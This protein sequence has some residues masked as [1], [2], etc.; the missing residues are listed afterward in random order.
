MKSSEYGGRSISPSK[1]GGALSQTTKN[2]N[3]TT[4]NSILK[5]KFDL[6]SN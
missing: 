3:L 6:K 1:N 2:I 5:N 4:N